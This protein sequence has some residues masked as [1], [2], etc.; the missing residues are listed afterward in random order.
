MK[1]IIFPPT[2]KRQIQIELI[3]NKMFPVSVFGMQK[4]ELL[5]DLPPIKDYEF[6]VSEFARYASIEY[7]IKMETLCNMHLA[8]YL[9][10]NNDF[11]ILDKEIANFK[12]ESEPDLDNLSD[13]E[14]EAHQRRYYGKITSINGRDKH[15][16]DVKNFADQGFIV[17]LWSFNEK[18]LS[19]MLRMLS[20]HSGIQ[21]SIPGKWDDVLKAFADFEIDPSKIPSIKESFDEL[22]VLNNKIKHLGEVDAKLAEF[23]GFKGRKGAQLE[24][25]EFDLQRY[26]NSSYAFFTFLAQELFEK[27][28]NETLKNKLLSLQKYT[29]AT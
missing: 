3:K 19:R 11:V 15:L 2:I 27:A 20:S 9:T 26:L 14:S 17:Q 21:F 4:T 8:S 29:L 16:K 25:F 18:H 7:F 1:Q 22:R 5:N 13:E 28:N 10:I 6:H 12:S 24:E 23:S